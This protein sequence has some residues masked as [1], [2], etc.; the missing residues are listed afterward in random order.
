MRNKQASIH[1]IL[2]AHQQNQM[3]RRAILASGNSPEFERMRRVYSMILSN[4]KTAFSG[5]GTMD[6]VM[7]QLDNPEVKEQ[8]GLTY[9]SEI[10]N[11]FK[12]KL[13]GLHKGEFTLIGNVL[14]ARGLTRKLHV[15]VDASHKPKTEYERIIANRLESA[16]SFSET[17]KVM[18]QLISA[19]N[20]YEVAQVAGVGTDEIRDALGITNRREITLPNWAMTKWENFNKS[21]FRNMPDHKLIVVQLGITIAKVSLFALLKGT[22][23]AT[24]GLGALKVVGVL[25]LI[26][27][28]TDTKSTAQIVR[29]I[30]VSTAALAPAVIKD[31]AKGFRF[32]GDISSRIWE[33]G[34][35]LF[36]KIFRRA[37]VQQIQEMLRNNSRFRQAYLAV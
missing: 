4:S 3:I 37:A 11:H 28:I 26:C 33:G 12:E 19:R 18:G 9:I 32:L 23:L 14:K 30:G 25:L 15:L 10:I 24:V 2:V 36:K 16:G 31:L 7:D 8:V 13:F 17:L 22:A 20:P 35:S 6:D 27:L 29:K 5:A 1:N 21:T 34:K